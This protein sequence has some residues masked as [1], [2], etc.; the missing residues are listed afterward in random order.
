MEGDEYQDRE[1]YFNI[2]CPKCKYEKDD[3]GDPK[4]PCYDC[5]MDTVNRNSHK[6]TYFHSKD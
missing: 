6:P 3:E 2:Y 5:L 4:S 1:V